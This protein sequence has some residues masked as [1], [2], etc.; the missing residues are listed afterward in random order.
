MQQV[1]PIK[2]EKNLHIE[3][4]GPQKHP[5]E[6]PNPLKEMNG[7]QTLKFFSQSKGAG[8]WF[9][10]GGGVSRLLNIEISFSKQRGRKGRGAGFTAYFALF[11]F[12]LGGVRGVCVSL[13]AYFPLHFV[14]ACLLSTHTLRTRWESHSEAFCFAFE[15]ISMH[16]RFGPHEF[17]EPFTNRM[18]YSTF[19]LFMLGK[20]VSSRLVSSHLISSRLIIIFGPIPLSL[21]P[22]N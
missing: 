7:F 17:K 20:P 1:G 13:D 3:V 6:A 14:I 2:R 21:Q 4:N 22:S 10:G 15:R 9:V 12:C 5:R 19:H 8:R 18:I 11:S 16:E